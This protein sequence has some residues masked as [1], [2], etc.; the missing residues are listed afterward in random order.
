MERGLTLGVAESLTGGLVGAGSAA[1]PGASEWFRGSIVA[2]A[3]EVKRTLL[4]VGDG[5]VVSEAAAEEMALGA[6]AA[7][8]ADVGLSLPGWPARPS[9]T[10]SRSAPCGSDLA[11]TGRPKVAWL[12]LPG[13]RDQIRQ[14]ATISALDLLRHRLL[15]GPPADW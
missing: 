4:G 2:Y 3:S 12:H 8:G 7:L 6:V 11:S 9:R 14:I 15:G 13:D 5:P 1:V 10:V